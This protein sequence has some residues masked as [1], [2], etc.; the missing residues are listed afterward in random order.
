MKM[1]MS[2]GLGAQ[3]HHRSSMYSI[4]KI[5]LPA[6]VNLFD[7][8]PQRGKGIEIA[9]PRSDWGWMEKERTCVIDTC[10]ILSRSVTAR[11]SG[12]NAMT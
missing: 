1:M 2:E 4:L 9:I 8:E 5:E 7:A 3:T 12:I 6:P 11:T 10:A